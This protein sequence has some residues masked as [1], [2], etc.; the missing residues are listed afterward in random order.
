LPATYNDHLFS[1]F[2]HCL[3][4]NNESHHK[5]VYEESRPMVEKAHRAMIGNYPRDASEQEW[6]VFIREGRDEVVMSH[7]DTLAVSRRQ[8][9]RWLTNKRRGCSP[10]TRPMCG[11]VRSTPSRDTRPT[12]WIGTQSQSTPT[13]TNHVLTKIYQTYDFD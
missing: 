3:V 13:L 1:W 7:F 2:T 9:M 11:S 12:I 6:E 5:N 10:G 8:I 4:R